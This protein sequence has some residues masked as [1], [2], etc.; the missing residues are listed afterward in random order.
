VHEAA[1][2]DGRQQKREGEIMAEHA[3]VEIAGVDSDCVTRAEGD[4]FEDATVLAQSDFAFGTAVQ[5]IEDC[6]GQPTTRQGAEVGDT[7]N[8]G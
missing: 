4:V 6:S 1:V 7:D 3:G 2:A 5:I 8:V